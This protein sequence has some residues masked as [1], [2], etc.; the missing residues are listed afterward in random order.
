MLP[1]SPA[2]HAYI[3]PARA[4]GRWWRVL[5]GLIAIVLAWFGMGLGMVGLVSGGAL[6]PLGI[7]PDAADALMGADRAMP[8]SG[9]LFFLLTFG[10]LWIGLWVAVRLIH[11]RPFGTLIH[12][13]GR[14]GRRTLLRGAGLAL[15]LYIASMIAYVAALGL[16]ERTELP[17]SVWAVWLVPIL[18]AIVIQASSEELLFRGYILQHFACWSRHPLIW[19]VI[20]SVIFAVLHY[21]PGME[22][23]MRTRMLVHIFSIGII[24]AALVWRTGGLEA[25]IG[26]HVTNNALAIGGAGMEGSAFGFELWLFP[27]DTL[28]RMIA[29]D[30]A[31]SVLILA[32]V[33]ILFKPEGRP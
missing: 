12:P 33:F 20:P 19:A 23:G 22:A 21:D 26:L 3:E 31:M 18:L 2:F 13:S 11:R 8:P 1:E 16:P 14:V 5:L 6:A 9:V 10:G 32:A 7:G 25:A 29:F 17:L 15:G 24:M 27:P 4:K 30:L 28:E